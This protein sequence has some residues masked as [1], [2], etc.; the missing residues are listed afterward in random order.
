MPNSASSIMKNKVM[1]QRRILAVN[2]Y[3]ETVEQW[4]DVTPL[5]AS[6]EPLRGQE[7]FK[8]QAFFGSF[9]HFP[10]KQ[11]NVDARIRIRYRKGLNPAENRIVYGGGN[12]NILSIIH[13][14]KIRE[15]QLMVAA[16]AVLQNDFSTVNR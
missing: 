11:A 9:G 8:S 14:R 13:N 1:L 16:K 12:Y 10:Q 6:F 5:N 7:F 4:E 15:T 3:G 2:D